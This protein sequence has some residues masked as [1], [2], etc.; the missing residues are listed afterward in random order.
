MTLFEKNEKT[1][2]WLR[3]HRKAV[4]ITATVI[5]IT[6]TFVILIING[7]RVKIPIK[8][9]AER[10]VQEVPSISNHTSKIVKA[11]GQVVP[12]ITRDT[13]VLEVNGVMKSFPRSEFIRHLHDGWHASSAKI[14]EAAKKGIKLKPGETFVNACTVT[15]KAF[16]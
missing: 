6:G 16:S 4:F 10:I 3:T 14:A 15:L 7:K 13:V 2:T 1:K 12:E 9:L 8:E 5:A 11:T